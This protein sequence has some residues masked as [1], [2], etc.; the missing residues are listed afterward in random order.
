LWRSYELR[1]L[2]DEVWRGRLSVRD[3]FFPGYGSCVVF[4]VPSEIPGF[5]KLGYPVSLPGVV[6]SFRSFCKSVS[7]ALL[8]LSAISHVASAQTA[9]LGYVES[10][11]AWSYP[12]GVAVDASG[13]V[14]IADDVDDVVQKF[15][16]NGS[17]GYT[18]T[19]ME[20]GFAGPTAVAVD[21]SG[22]VYV[23]DTDNSLV[24]EIPAGCSSSACVTTLGGGFNLPNGVAVDTS[25]NIYVGD[26][27]NGAVKKMAPGCTSSACV[28]TLGGGFSQPYGVAVDA[29]GNVYV[30]DYG[31]SAV[32]KMAPGCT[33]S[34]CVTTLGGGFNQPYGVAVD[35]GGNV[36]VADFGNKALKE[37]PS[38]CTSST[39]VVTI[40]GEFS[41]P[42]G[43]AVDARGN[44]YVADGGDGQVLLLQAGSRNFGSVAVG[45]NSTQT[46]IFTFDTGGTLASTP[47]G[48]LTQGVPN[49]DFSAA[50]GSCATGTTYNAGDTCT[51]NVTFTPAFASTRYGAGVLYGSTGAVIATGYVYGTGT[52][53]QVAFLPA[54][55]ST[56]GTGLATPYWVAVDAGG[57]AYIA[58]P[59]NNSVLK[60]T[61]SVGSYTQSTIGSGLSSP[62]SVAV[63]GA[64][65][66][67]ITDT[68]AN[69]V[70]KLTPSGGSYIESS[71]GPGTNNPWGVAVDGSGNVYVTDSMDGLVLKE[72]LSSGT[73]TQSTVASG[74]SNPTGIA[75]DANGNLY[76][77]DAAASIVVKETPAGGSYVQSTIVGSGLS[78]PFG[79]A[80]AANGDLYIADYGNWAVHR[81]VPNGSGVYVKETDVI[82]GIYDPLGVALDGAGNVYAAGVAYS[83]SSEVVRFDVADAPSLT[84]PLTI[85]SLTSASQ[86]VTLENIGNGSLSLPIPGTGNNPSISPNFT[87]DS[88][89][90]G[91]CPLTGSAS[92]S[93]GTL[94]AGASCTLPVSFAPTAAGSATGSLV[95]TDTSLNA[96]ASPYVTQ[97]IVLK[98]TATAGPATHF[99]VS[100]PAT[101]IAGSPV[102]VTVTAQVAD[103]NT[104]TNYSGTVHFTSSDT[105]AALP[106]NST[107]TNGVGTFT[108]TLFTVGTQTITATDTATSSI[109]GSASLN[110]SAISTTLTP[111]VTPGSS[112]VYGV[113]PPAVS[114]ALTPSTATGISASQFTATLDGTTSLKVVSAA[115]N[116]FKL[117]GIPTTL[118]VGSHTIAVSF[119]G[120]STYGASSLSIPLTVTPAT[121]ILTAASATRVYGAVNPA[122]TG[123]ISGAVNGD[124]F[125]EAFATSAT[126]S[127]N[128]GTYA[129]VP[130]ATGTNLANYT[131]VANNGTLTITAT[132][133]TLTFAPL[134]TP[135][136]YGVAPVTLQATPGASGTPV[137]FSAQGPATV[138]GTT[139]TYTGAGTVFVT[140][141][142]AASG[143]YT[144]ATPVQQTVVVNKATPAVTIT[145]SPATS[146]YG[147]DT[148]LLI[149]VTGVPF[150]AVPTG[151]VILVLDGAAHTLNL[152]VGSASYDAGVL[153]AGPHTGVVTYSGDTN[154]LS[155]VSSTSATTLVTVGTASLN[156]TAANATRLYG[157]ANPTFSGSVT[158]AVN[159]DI[160][161]EGFSTTA[162][163]SSNAG[164]YPIIPLVS[165]ADLADYTVQT[166]D[167]VLTITRAGS[168]T[169][170]NSST[171]NL[172][173]GAPVTL[174]AAVAST[175]TGTPTGTVTFFNGTTQVGTAT[176]SS[177][178]AS[179]TTS[180]AATGTDS[181]TAVYAGD[182]NFTGSSSGSVA[183]TVV[184]SGFRLAGT[185]TTVY[186]TAGQSTQVALTLASFGNL[187]GTVTLSCTLPKAL[188]TCAFAPQTITFAGDNSTQSAALTVGTY[189]P[190]N[191]GP[192]ATTVSGMMWLPAVLLGGLLG[193]GRRRMGAPMR[194]LLLALLLM[195]AA[196]GASG[197]GSGYTSAAAGSDSI[198]VTATGP[199]GL[200]QT[201]TVT[202]NVN[203]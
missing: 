5:M 95:L 38:G 67:Y 182:T 101:T 156:V 175:T 168:T 170:L 188:V 131:V 197:C 75:V 190:G 57:N 7:V 121:L 58:D 20:G 152:G 50:S 36:Y 53:P 30:A 183:V 35:A 138:S 18:S 59:G 130:S 119:A 29:S 164:V 49:L 181:I 173:T 186:L 91:T 98:G 14:Y 120:T 116:T 17:G 189:G 162:I 48:A 169:S 191:Y 12:A 203:N 92:S 79:L 83:G 135:V 90:T 24:K 132:S 177:G 37:M 55:Q 11:I 150:G 187:T 125:T 8:G 39:C 147:A 52:G 155:V 118:G 97:T 82:N 63:D 145:A 6:S 42:W 115:T 157:T 180:F 129:I 19:A 21:T 179:L 85:I 134:T 140:A 139:L 146:T 74:L 110:V 31:N 195:S 163:V 161:T 32:R 171:S 192:P 127:S 69:Q 41:A 28:T 143:N 64:G 44:L 45:S 153:S 68:G 199:A 202:V 2:R 113:V 54:S 81:Y 78:F 100:A 40:G 10:L 136:T 185:P 102:T 149:K 174:T 193:L 23:A 160:F 76:V 104:A 25:G 148:L 122:F 16:P 4:V 72:T 142:E 13:N 80:V 105:G 123:T 96:T 47:Y 33:S 178:I 133:Q 15:T 93:A 106:A 141:S 26:S 201:V 167:G 103:N 109:T 99:S 65:D 43:V 88:T 151:S 34:A 176:L 9:H 137:T 61:F 108:V 126:P 166:T 194:R 158:G 62:V 200:T 71:V 3:W 114:V 66:V 128:A 70:L 107:L 87:L 60:E 196:F 86:T 144:A 22:D 198:T 159:N 111:T 154:Y 89:S 56:I 172:G 84:F 73:Y 27:A 165:G 46:L 112:Y 94:A 117:T 51:V 184:P 1:R 124:T 77:S